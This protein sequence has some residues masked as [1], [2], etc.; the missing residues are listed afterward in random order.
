MPFSRRRTILFSTLVSTLAGLAFSAGAWAQSDPVFARLDS[1]HDG[2][3]SLSEHGTAEKATFNRMD[4]DHDGKL[5]AQEMASVH[6]AMTQVEIAAENV[7]L[8]AAQA[9][10]ARPGSKAA[11]PSA[12]D[13]A[14][15]QA[16]FDRLDANHDGTVSTAEMQAAHSQP[17]PAQSRPAATGLGMAAVL[18]VNHDGFVSATE[19][20]AIARARFARM[21]TNGDGFVSSQEWDAAH[22][23]APASTKP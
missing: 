23:K 16:L 13:A 1:N 6:K 14:V 3:I 9:K 22:S 5:S 18:D 21:D 17:P 8:A 19:H 2:R 4:A 10:P 11:T 12:E 7:E 15:Q 20:A